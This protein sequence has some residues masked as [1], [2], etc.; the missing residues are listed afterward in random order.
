MYMFD[1][2]QHYNRPIVAPMYILVCHTNGQSIRNTIGAIM[3]HLVG[4][5]L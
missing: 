5:G 3:N 1:L 2:N 4:M